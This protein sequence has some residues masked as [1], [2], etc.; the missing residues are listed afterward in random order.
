MDI[1]D[2][3]EQYVFLHDAILE[4]VICGDTQVNAADLRHIMHKY[5]KA[6][7]STG[8]TKFESQ[9]NVSVALFRTHCT[10][11]WFSLY[12]NLHVME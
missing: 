6:D 4:S 2:L 10:A 5:T 9:F 8:L 3:Q 12:D 11:D 1:Y 7:V